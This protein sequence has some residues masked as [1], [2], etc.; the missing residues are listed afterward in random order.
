MSQRTLAICKPD[1]VMKGVVEKIIEVYTQAGLQIECWR[2]IKLDQDTASRLYAAHKGLPHF[3]GLILAMTA[4]DCIAML[5]SGENAVPRVRAING[6]TK[7]APRGTL[8]GDFPSAGGPFNIVHGSDT[9]VA[10][11]R[12]IAI[13]FPDK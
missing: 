1:A 5:I 10:A 4:G 3:E 12:E 9:P 6:P 2:R 11:A 8:R 13:F 7:D